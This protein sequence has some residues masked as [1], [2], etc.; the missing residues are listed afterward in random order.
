MKATKFSSS[1]NAAVPVGA[2]HVGIVVVR[3]TAR[4]GDAN[5][6]EFGPLVLSASIASRQPRS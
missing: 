2:D 5:A 6:V 1:N 3:V 4:Y